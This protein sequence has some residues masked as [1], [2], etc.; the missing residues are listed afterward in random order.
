MTERFGNPPVLSADH[1]WRP[2][3]SWLSFSALLGSYK[4]K[5][6]QRFQSH[7]TNPPGGIHGIPHWPIYRSTSA[8]RYCR[9]CFNPNQ[10]CGIDRGPAQPELSI[11]PTPQCSNVA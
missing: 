6:V 11:V 10:G 4:G 1:A 5:A 7:Q 9:C 3:W 2:S 8:N